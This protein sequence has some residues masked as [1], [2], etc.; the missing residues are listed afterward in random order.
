MSAPCSLAGAGVLITRPGAQAENLARLVS[1][2]GGRP[3]AFPTIEILPACDSDAAR[4]RLAEPWD[5]ILFVSRNAVEYGRALGPP[6]GFGAAM[7]GAVGRATA[8]ALQSAGLPTQL[9]PAAGFDSESLLALPELTNVAGKRVLIVRG[10]GGRPLL[11]E[12]LSL[13]GADVHYAEVYRRSIPAVEIGPQLPQWRAEVGFVTATSDEVLNN[14]MQ[15]VGKAG[16]D[17]LLGTPLVVISER[18]AGGAMQL[19]F[20]TVA[21]ADEA[22]DAGIVEALCRLALSRSAPR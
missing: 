9:V 20:R 18:G 11:A 13:R 14:L 4:A 19:G 10:E 15:M 12:T 3:I 7:I 5:L 17:W 8:A 6:R 21:V 2:A 16:R 1:A 22:S